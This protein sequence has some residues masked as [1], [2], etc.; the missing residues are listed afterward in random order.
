[1]ALADAT[2]DSAGDGASFHIDDIDVALANAAPVLPVDFTFEWPPYRVSVRVLERSSGIA[3]RMVVDMGVFPYTAENPD[4]RHHMQHLRSGNI[5][6]PVGNFTVTEQRRLA[7]CAETPIEQPATGG[8]IVAAIARTLL[9]AR[10]YFG[11]AR[12]PQRRKPN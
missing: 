12:S 8:N 1:M 7:F 6:F 5:R 10:P 4:L 11:L 3:C 2:V 9:A